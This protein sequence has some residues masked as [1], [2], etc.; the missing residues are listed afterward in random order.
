MCPWLFL[1]MASSRLERRAPVFRN[2]AQTERTVRL[3]WGR[4]PYACPVVPYSGYG[5]FTPYLSLPASS[6]IVPLR[7]HLKSYSPA[8]ITVS[9]GNGGESRWDVGRMDG[10]SGPGGVICVRSVYPRGCVQVDFSKRHRRDYGEEMSTYGCI[11]AWGR[12]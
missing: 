8:T 11:S 1:D 7:A 9:G 6:F 3:S 10:T 4:G 12:M 5:H 2:L